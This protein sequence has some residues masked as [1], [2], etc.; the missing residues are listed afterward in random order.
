MT[1]SGKPAGKSH[2][3]PE[4]SGRNQDGTFASGQ[5]GNKDGKPRGALNWGTKFFEAVNAGEI[6]GI[7]RKT[8]DEAK[9]GNMV[10]AKLIFDRVM[11]VPKG[12][13]VIL[14]PSYR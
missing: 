2:G 13:P 11:P 14:D 5:S 4:N 6:E 1:S 3:Q 12:R 7:F 9:A 8:I 10:A